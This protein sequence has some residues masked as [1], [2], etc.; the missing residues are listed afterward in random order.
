MPR[1]D[2][3]HRDAWST[4]GSSRKS[5][6]CGR[7]TARGP[8]RIRPGPSPAPF[9][10]VGGPIGGVLGWNGDFLSIHANW[11]LNRG[12]LPDRMSPTVFGS[13]QL[14]AAGASRL[15]CIR[16]IGGPAR[17]AVFPFVSG[18]GR[19]FSPVLP[20]LVYTRFSPPS[21]AANGS[22][23]WFDREY[24]FDFANRVSCGSLAIAI[25]RAWWNVYSAARECACR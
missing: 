3:L 4:G 17:P 10:A 21:A 11:A 24:A 8:A 23:E 7:S 5:E 2:R 16:K 14:H 22:N 25:S 20:V 12:F 9:G 6:S 13:E 19:C 15:A 18:A 1:A